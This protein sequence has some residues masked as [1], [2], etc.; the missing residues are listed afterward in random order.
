MPRLCGFYPGICLATEEKAR[1]KRQGKKN[2]WQGT[3]Y[4]SPK[5]PHITTTKK[6]HTHTHHTH[7]H[8]YTHTHITHIHTHTH[9]HH[10]HTTHT[11][12]IHT[13][14]THHTHT[15]HTHT[16]KPDATTQFLHSPPAPYV[17]I[18]LQI[19][20]QF[21]FKPT[22]ILLLIPL[23]YYSFLCSCRLYVGSI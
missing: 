7:T 5:H 4:I 2:L 3:V 14:H 17:C 18:A 12:H 10:T 20:F 6:T 23:H 9:T 13:P 21:T 11:T 1:K 22:F 15:H 19:Y 16:H 8:T